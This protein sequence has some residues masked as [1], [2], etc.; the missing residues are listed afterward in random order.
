M[1]L[2]K[3]A[4]SIGLSDG[5]AA[6]S[7]VLAMIALIHSCSSNRTAEEANSIAASANQLAADTA[8]K[9]GDYVQ[10]YPGF[11]LLMPSDGSGWKRYQS[12]YDGPETKISLDEWKN[13][14]QRIFVVRLLNGGAQDANIESIFLNPAE[15]KFYGTAEHRD[16]LDPLCQ[17]ANDEDW[18]PCP[19]VISPRNGYSL[20]M[21]ITK[22]FV[23]QLSEDQRQRGIH[24]CAQTTTAEQGCGDVRVELPMGAA[25]AM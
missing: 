9:Q 21:N 19:P 23:Q 18:K 8:K 10:I 20:R 22:E 13:A 4:K 12:H 3:V 14:T 6:V 24:I 15:G 7:V 25:D 1:V 11:V 2:L 5:I 17:G 16:A